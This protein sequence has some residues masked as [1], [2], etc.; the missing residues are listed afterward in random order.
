MFPNSH[1]RWSLHPEMRHQ[2]VHVG[3]SKEN[4]RQP[5]LAFDITNT[6]PRFD[7][8]ILAMNLPTKKEHATD[9][10]LKV[11]KLSWPQK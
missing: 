8:F 2:K 3:V 7:K 10:Y 1:G 11:K 5:N 4:Q 6:Y 9:N